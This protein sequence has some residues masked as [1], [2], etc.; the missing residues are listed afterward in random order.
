[1]S[2]AEDSSKTKELVEYGM[3]VS[4]ADDSL[5]AKIAVA[6]KEMWEAFYVDVPDAKSVVEAYT[7]KVGK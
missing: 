4:N 3:T 2:A 5:K 7:A 1:M 6:G